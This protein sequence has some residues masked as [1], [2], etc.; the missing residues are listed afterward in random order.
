MQHPGAAAGG[1]SST[2]RGEGAAGPSVHG[3]RRRYPERQPNGNSGASPSPV[4]SLHPQ[5]QAGEAGAAAL[6]PGHRRGTGPEAAP[7]GPFSASAETPAG[8]RMPGGGRPP[9]RERGL[10]PEP[11]QLEGGGGGRGEAEKGAGGKWG[12]C[13]L[14]APP[15]AGAMGSAGGARAAPSLLLSLLLGASAPLWLRAET[16]GECGAGPGRAAGAALGERGVLRATPAVLAS[17]LC[18]SV[19]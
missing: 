5:P 7:H 9:P 3:R 6:Q 14:P 2:R 18:G 11:P 19:A 16:L 1:R 13:A 12:S 15:R 8:G 4:S 17:L 10:A